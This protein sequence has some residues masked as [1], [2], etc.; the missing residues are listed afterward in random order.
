MGCL[1]TVLAFPHWT[2]DE[3]K[4]GDGEGRE[5]DGRQQEFRQ[6][7]CQR[8]SSFL[9]TDQSASLGSVCGWPEIICTC[10]A[11]IQRHPNGSFITS[12]LDR[13]NGLG[14]QVK[15]SIGS[16]TCRAQL[17]GFSLAPNPWQHITRFIRFQPRLSGFFWDL[18]VVHVVRS[19]QTHLPSL[20]SA[21]MPSQVPREYAASQSC[22][23]EGGYAESCNET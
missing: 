5:R 4:D 6:W 15:P 1:C 9:C 19:H 10:A 17:P 16:S 13:C 12:R 21:S 11:A 23:R 8:V 3:R 2:A 18:T 14:F 22:E 20:E 7:I